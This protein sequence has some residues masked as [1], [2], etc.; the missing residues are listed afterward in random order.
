MSDR[1]N[2]PD[3]FRFSAQHFRTARKHRRSMMSHKASISVLV[4]Q[5]P[6]RTT[7]DLRNSCPSPALR[8]EDQLATCG[9]AQFLAYAGNPEASKCFGVWE[10]CLVGVDIRHPVQTSR[11][12]PPRP[13]SAFLVGPLGPERAQMTPEGHPS[14]TAHNKPLSVFLPFLF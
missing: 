2:G 8:S 9:E 1:P 7:P 10:T 3:R 14:N 4:R 13:V 12:C 11:H 6:S 5:L